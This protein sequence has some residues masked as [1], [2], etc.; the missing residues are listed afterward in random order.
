MYGSPSEGQA[1]LDWQYRI[2]VIRYLEDPPSPREFINLMEVDFGDGTG[3]HDV[4]DEWHESLKGLFDPKMRHTFEQPGEYVVVIRATFY[5]GE[6]H[7]SVPK[8][9]RVT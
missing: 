8:T 7:L 2:D 1:P 4:T 5:D 3:W 6:Q 9:I